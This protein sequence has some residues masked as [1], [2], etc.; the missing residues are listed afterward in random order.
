[1]TFALAGLATGE[2]TAGDYPAAFET[3]ERVL[4]L[5]RESGP[6]LHLGMALLSQGEI[7]FLMRNCEIARERWNESLSQAQEDQDTF[8]IAYSL[9]Y[10]GDLARMEQDY[11]EA[12]AKYQ[13]SEAL[14]RELNT[15]GYLAS[16]LSNLGFTYLY[17]GEIE[18]AQAKFHESM[19]IYQAVQ[20]TR[21]MIDDLVGLAAAAIRSSLPTV[22]ARL[23]A[24]VESLAGLP[25]ASTWPPTKMEFERY[26]GLAR[27]GLTE[28][29]FQEQMAIGQAMNLE[30]SVAYAQNIPF[31]QLG[32]RQAKGKADDLTEREREVARLIAEGK[33]NRQ[34]ANELVLSQRTVE[35]HAANILS[36]LGL[37]SRAQI[38]RWVM[39]KGPSQASE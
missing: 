15:Q 16:I 23:L 24:A 27:E 17:L 37:T 11:S 26:L 10:L 21:G 31:H 28:A 39:E 36:K 6:R 33:T 13:E 18:L 5:Y 29:S 1:M 7:A 34:I 35:K 32:E 3:G 22:G 20:N 8:R 25:A 9:N 38:V 12:A 4:Q 30:Q 19:A 14:L 2:K